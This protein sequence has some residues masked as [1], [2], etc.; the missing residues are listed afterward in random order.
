MIDLQR[1]GPSGDPS[2]TV[3]DFIKTRTYDIDGDG[4]G[5]WTIVPWGRR[6]GFA[7]DDLAE[8]VRLCV[9]RLLDAG[10]VPVRHSPSG[11]LMLWQEQTQYGTTHDQIADGIV[12]EWLGSGGGDPPWGYLWFVTREVLEN[13]RR[14]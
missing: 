9:M 13:D 8:F 10:A 3:A 2:D 4:E 12:A 7:G 14:E 6:F 1:R 11:K 5:L